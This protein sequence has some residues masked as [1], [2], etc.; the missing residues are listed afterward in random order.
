MALVGLGTT[1]GGISTSIKQ[2][3]RFEPIPY[4]AE[5]FRRTADS[6]GHKDV[7]TTVR[8]W[9]V[10]WRN[11]TYAEWQALLAFWDTTAPIWLQDLEGGTWKVVPV[12][13]LPSPAG[14]FAG[15]TR[16]YGAEITFEWVGNVFIIGLST[17]GG[18]DIFGVG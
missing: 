14:R 1:L 17:I 13:E 3:D 4:R 9:Q 10:G 16:R 18:T 15:G 7:G 2:P 5:R 6:V 11:L 12:G 8:R